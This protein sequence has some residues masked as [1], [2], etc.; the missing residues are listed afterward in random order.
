MNALSGISTSSLEPPKFGAEQDYIVVGEQP[1]LDG[2][3]SGPGVV[4]QVREAIFKSMDMSYHFV[5]S[6]VR[7]C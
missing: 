4:R 3:V 1:W 7:C 2:I 6:Q 5:F